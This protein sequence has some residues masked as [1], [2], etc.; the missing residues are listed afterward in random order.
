M[1]PPPPSGRPTHPQLKHG[2]IDGLCAV[3][4]ERLHDGGKHALTEGHLGRLEVA[5][6]LGRLEDELAAAAG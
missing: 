6:A 1:T 2:R 4:F 3:A 5:R